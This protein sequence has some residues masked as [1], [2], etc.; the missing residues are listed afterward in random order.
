MFWVLKR[1]VPALE[2]RRPGYL[3]GRYTPLFAL[4]DLRKDLDFALTLFATSGAATPLTH[5]SSELVAKA[6]DA[7]PDLDISAVVQP[8]RD[9]AQASGTVSLA[10]SSPTPASR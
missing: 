6:A 2:A 5:S 4:R 10:N 7:N 9:G 3:E 1:I 8:Y